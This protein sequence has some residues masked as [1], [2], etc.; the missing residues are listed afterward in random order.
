MRA[1]SPAW[2]WDQVL[3]EPEFS[4]L[5][6]EDGIVGFLKSG[7]AEIGRRGL[8]IGCGNGRHTLAALGCGF[9]MAAVDISITALSNTGKL[10]REH[11]HDALLLAASMDALPFEDEVFDFVMSFC[12]LNHGEKTQFLGA[13]LESFRVLRTG[14]MAYGFVMTQD[15]PRFGHGV[16]AGE[17][18]YVFTEGLEAG[19]PHYFPE[20]R[21]LLDVLSRLGHVV[22]FN[23]VR[24]DAE[25]IRRI[26]PIASYSA[27]V[28]FV[29]QK[30]RARLS[31]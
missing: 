19:I 4:S 12:V 31:R 14:G 27:H 1:D 16:N 21:Q 17:N 25:E 22:K 5:I 28:E 20:R 9:Q 6:P 15:D 8:D 7:I 24:C 11:G 13:L 18:C 3:L 23:P 26:H 10:V 30:R 29:V 2:R